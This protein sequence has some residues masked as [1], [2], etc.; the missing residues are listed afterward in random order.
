M[1]GGVPGRSKWH[2]LEQRF[3]AAYTIDSHTECWVWNG[4][5]WNGYGQ[6]IVKGKRCAGHRV[7][8]ELYNGPIPAGQW[9]LHKCDNPKCVNPDHLFLGTH[10]ENIQDMVQ[11]R[12][13]VKGV[14]QGL[15]KL[16]EAQVLEIRDMPGQYKDVGRLFGVSAANVCDIKKRHTWKHL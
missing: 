10:L 15:C 12:R 5:L 3:H 6:I 9:V 11:K 4:C 7:S 8:W 2:T 14:R 13:Q 1:R 16:T